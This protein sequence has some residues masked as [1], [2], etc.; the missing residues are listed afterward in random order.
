MDEPEF[1]LWD[2]HPLLRLLRFVDVEASGLHDGSYPIQFGWCGIDLKTSV[3]LVRPEPEWTPHLFNPKAFEIHGISYDHAKKH[4]TDAM[5]VVH[6]LN[7]A[8]EGKAA[9]VDSPHY[10]GYWT[11]R[12]AATTGLPVKFGYNDFSKIASTFGGVFDR[13]CIARHDQLSDAVKRM[14]PHTHQAD[15]D[16]L[17]MAALTRMCLDREWAEWVLDRPLPAQGGSADCHP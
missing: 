10:D 6:I 7:A 3:I 9:I 16:A 5:E 2:K 14:Y 4:G 12:L 17:R 1:K 11:T 8:L 13:W 15:D